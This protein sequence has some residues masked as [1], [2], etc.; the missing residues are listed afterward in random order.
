M[1]FEKKTPDLDFKPITDGLGFHPFSDGLPYSPSSK[2]LRVGR[3]IAP[4]PAVPSTL[5]ETSRVSGAVAAGL[6]SFA[7]TL[8]KPIAPA[9]P[10]AAPKAAVRVAKSAP[11]PVQPVR[12]EAIASPAEASLFVLFKRA[13]AYVLDSAFNITLC[14]TAL[15]LSLMDQGIGFNALYDWQTWF[16]GAMFLLFFNWSLIVGQEI[17]FRSTLFKRMFGLR[18]EGPV[19]AIFVRAILFVPS[20]LFCGIGLVWAFGDSRRRCWHDLAT[21]VHVETT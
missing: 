15:T 14:S 8:P 16:S 19:L 6:P 11:V 5:K 3:A 13:L 18:L 12:P 1:N 20:A 4:M 21:G 10:K 2:D 7:R 9:T 17:A